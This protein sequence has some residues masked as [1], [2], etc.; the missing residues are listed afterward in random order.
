MELGAHSLYQL[1]NND[2]RSEDPSSLTPWANYL[3][4]FEIALTKLPKEKK[5][6]WCGTKDNVNQ[7][8]IKGSEIIW[9]SVSSCSTT[10]N[11]IKEFLGND[12]NATLFMIEAVNGRNLSGYTKHPDENEVLLGPGTRLS[13]ESDDLKLNDGLKVLH[14]VE[15]TDKNNE[16]L[17]AVINTISIT[18]KPEILTDMKHDK[19][20]IQE[21]VAYCRDWHGNEFPKQDIEQ[22]QQE[23]HEHSPIWWYTAPHFLYSVLEY[24]LETLDF[25]AIIKLGFF[26][27]DLHEQLGKLHSERFK[28][29][30]GKLTVYRGQGLPKSDLQKLKSH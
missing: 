21:F 15:I 12:T 6:L 22:F 14:V 1:L 11:I 5:R 25:E 20:L 2:L 19:R 30:K 24:S 8:F 16:T 28:K 4:L 9:R 17:P 18:S 23:Y 10:L 13:V 3:K 27:L 26:I 29:V 7:N